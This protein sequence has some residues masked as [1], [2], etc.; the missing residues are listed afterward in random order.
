MN[1]GKAIGAGVVA[2][3]VSVVFTMLTCGW[4]FNW[5]YKI[6]PTALWKMPGMDLLIYGNLLAILVG[7]ILS[8]VFALLFR[9]IPGKKLQKGLMFGFLVWILAVPGISVQYFFMNIAGAVILYWLVNILIA[10]LLMG[11]VIA[12]IY[13]KG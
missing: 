10:N 6:E 1:W 5:V 2:G 13:K 8:I 11:L 3:I 4:L 9:A 12:A 7:I